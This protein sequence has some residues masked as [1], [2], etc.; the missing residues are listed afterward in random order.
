MK[1]QLTLT[2]WYL[3]MAY[4]IGT[5]AH[6]MVFG[7]YKFDDGSFIHTSRIV[8]ITREGGAL[9]IETVSG[10]HYQ[11]P[12]AKIDVRHMEESYSVAREW[13][14]P[15]MLGTWETWAKCI[16]GR[17]W[18]NGINGEP[19]EDKKAD[20]VKRMRSYLKGEGGLEPDTSDVLTEIERLAG[21][22]NL[23]KWCFR[24]PDFWERVLPLLQKRKDLSSVFFPK[25]MEHYRKTRHTAEWEEIMQTKFGTWCRKDREFYRTWFETLIQDWM[26]VASH[27]PSGALPLIYEKLIVEKRPKWYSD[28]D[29]FRMVL[30]KGDERGEGESCIWLSWMARFMGRKL[31]IS[32]RGE[33]SGTY[34]RK[35][36]TGEW[37]ERQDP[38]FLLFGLSVIMEAAEVTDE[39]GGEE[40]LP[41]G[42]PAS[43][44]TVLDCN[45]LDLFLEALRSGVLRARYMEQYMTYALDQGKFALIPGMMGCAMK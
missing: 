9:L 12:L 5:H 17:E 34:L 35:W 32:R 19:I 1:K 14:E 38:D 20:F 3:T 26:D 33:Y 10:S 16:E 45:D 23:T 43:D 42:F 8:D 21:E 11:A 29:F 4:A 22:L 39:E 27:I 36:L 40:E 7:H 6:G 18:M 37:K 25:F 31:Q 2:N 24:E 28:E 30:E 13:M 15:E 41:D 44:R